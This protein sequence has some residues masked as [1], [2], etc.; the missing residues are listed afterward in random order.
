MGKALPRVREP[1]RYAPKGAIDRAVEAMRANGIH[2][3]SVTVNPDGSIKLSAVDNP[4][5]RPDTLFDALDKQ[6]RLS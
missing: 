5:K 4:A 2:V 3:A 1:R 6:G